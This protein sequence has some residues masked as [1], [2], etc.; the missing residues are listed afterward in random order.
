MPTPGN[1]PACYPNF[2][3]VSDG[4]YLHQISAQPNHRAVSNYLSVW[5]DHAISL[6]MQFSSR[7]YPLLII[8][9]IYLFLLIQSRFLISSAS[10]KQTFYS[11]DGLLFHSS[12]LYTFKASHQPPACLRSN[13]SGRSSPWLLDLTPSITSRSSTSTK[14]TVSSPSLHNSLTS[15]NP[16]AQSCS[17]SSSSRKAPSS[18]TF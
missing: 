5:V 17:N 12:T 11:L 10:G 2:T 15:H 3:P 1:A 13:S 18:T 16:V 7:A 14:T 4:I 8:S 9:A 6:I